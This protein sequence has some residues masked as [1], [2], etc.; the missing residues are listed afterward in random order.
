MATMT[1]GVTGLLSG[2]LALISF[3]VNSPNYPLVLKG[4]TPEE[5]QKTIGNGVLKTVINFASLVQIQGAADNTVEADTY[6]SLPTK[7]M[8]QLTEA[9]VQCET[10][11]TM[12]RLAKQEVSTLPGMLGTVHNFCLTCTLVHQKATLYLKHTYGEN[13]GEIEPAWRKIQKD[14]FDVCIVEASDAVE[15]AIPLRL[16]LVSDIDKGVSGPKHCRTHTESGPYSYQIRDNLKVILNLEQRGRCGYVSGG[17]RY[18][19]DWKECKDVTEFVTDCR[20]SY[21]KNLEAEVRGYYEE[22]IREPSRKYYEDFKD[23]V[24]DLPQPP[25]YDSVPKHAQIS[26]RSSLESDAQTTL[27]PVFA[28]V[29]VLILLLLSFIACWRSKQ[30]AKSR[31]TNIDTETV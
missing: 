14:V 25:E 6:V 28:L 13:W 23:Q 3:A 16:N 1:G 20:N 24:P 15:T 21:L 26:S 18:W 10:Y 29:G 5:L 9:R 27:T 19:D 12:F 30:R 8:E 2:G 4:P 22:F 7:Y 31:E 11:I 17:K